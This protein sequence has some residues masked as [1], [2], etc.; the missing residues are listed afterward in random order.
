[1]NCNK[2]KKCTTTAIPEINRNHIQ[3]ANK[4][5]LSHDE[6][7]KEASLDEW[8][9]NALHYVA[10]YVCRHLRRKLEWLKGSQMEEMIWSLMTLTK[11]G[12]D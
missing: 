8:E 3:R 6:R 2:V 1:M 4:T 12:E 11:G 10:A 7:N 9:S 5:T